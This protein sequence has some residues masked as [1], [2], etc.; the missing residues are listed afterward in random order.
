RGPMDSSR[1]PECGAP[2]QPGA[3]QCSSCEMLLNP[4]VVLDVAFGDNP[5]PPSIVRG[6]LSLEEWTP[7]NAPPARPKQSGN[8]ATRR[9]APVSPVAVPRILVGIELATQSVHPLEAHVLSYVDGR[10]TVD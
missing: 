3:F 10:Q 6:M 1:C 4:E 9:W 2:V 8:E 5:D 7:G